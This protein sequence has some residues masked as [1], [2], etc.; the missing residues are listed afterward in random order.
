MAGAGKEDAVGIELVGATFGDVD[1]LPT[2]GAEVKMLLA[3]VV[4]IVAEVAVPDEAGPIELQAL[5]VEFRGD[6]F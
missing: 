3:V 2:V 4:G 5:D 6:I 1:V